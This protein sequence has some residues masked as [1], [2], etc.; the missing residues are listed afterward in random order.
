MK[1]SAV[2][3]LEVMLEETNED[4]K[5]LAKAMSQDLDV[6]AIM[7]TMKKL[8][9][10]VIL[11][12]EVIVTFIR[13]YLI[14]MSHCMLKLEEE[15]L[16]NNQLGS[17]CINFVYRAYHVLRKISDYLEISVDDYGKYIILR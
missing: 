14:L 9:V 11:Y 16:G 2:E 17:S 10:I 7:T 15:C 13:V 8:F 12:Q 4:S 1:A 6:D 3:L 5:L